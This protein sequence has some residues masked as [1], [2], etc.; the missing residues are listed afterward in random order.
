MA[1]IKL[2]NLMQVALITAIFAS[3]APVKFKKEAI[4]CDVGDTTC[5]VDPL[6]P[7]YLN[8]SEIVNVGAGQVDILFVDDN[9]ASMST[10]QNSIADKFPTFIQG[11]DNKGINYRI[12]VTTT[13]ITGVSGGASTT[14]ADAKDG[15]LVNLSNGKNFISAG[16]DDQNTRVNLFK[17]AIKR[18]E[19][20]TCENW[21]LSFAAGTDLTASYGQH[22][23]SQDERGVYAANLTI[24]KNPSSFIRASSHLAVV[25]ISDEENRSGILTLENNDLP[26]SLISQVKTKYPNKTLSTHAIVLKPNDTACFNEQNAQMNG[27]VRGSYGKSYL[28]LVSKTSGVEG[29]VCASDYGAQ[30][31]D[32]SY[33][34]IDR[35]NEV[36]LRC[37]N[38]EALTVNFTQGSTVSYSVQGDVL[39]FASN[40]SPN[41]QVQLSYKCKQN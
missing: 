3:C 25:I 13:D 40:L 29:S 16:E 14:P 30:L 38:A 37:A 21:I 27:R 31:G 10:E 17:T 4:K 39:K 23:P 6:A 41:T 18:N 32:I 36:K 20:T 1:Q 19:T 15:N 33:S 22:C 5:T 7:N 24:Q 34:I 11:L 2:H 26:D 9:S 12:G 35:V 8:Y 28:E